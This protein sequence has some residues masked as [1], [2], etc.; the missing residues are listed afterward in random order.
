[1]TD[2]DADWKTLFST[3]RQRWTAALDFG[4]ELIACA[5]MVFGAWMLKAVIS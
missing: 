3:P 4:A 2:P 5:V 1:M